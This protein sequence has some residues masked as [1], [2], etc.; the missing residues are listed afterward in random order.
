M[1]PATQRC[2]TATT[3]RVPGNQLESRRES[4]RG[5]HRI[6]LCGFLDHLA[7]LQTGLTA[8]VCGYRRVRRRRGSTLCPFVTPVLP[9]LW[10]DNEKW[11]LEILKG[12]CAKDPFQN[13]GETTLFEELLAVFTTQC[14][15]MGIYIH[16]SSFAL[17][18]SSAAP[19]SVTL[20]CCACSR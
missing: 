20:S 19:R 16:V 17:A 4:R 14:A 18:C 2:S 1:R 13:R 3:F 10:S 5:G 12:D 7:N 6:H 15:M 8:L 11:V 9:A